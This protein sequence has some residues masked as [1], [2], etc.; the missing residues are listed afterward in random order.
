MLLPAERPTRA[1]C[2]AVAA[3]VIAALMSSCTNAEQQPT[4]T[5]VSGAMTLRAQ[6]GQRSHGPASTGDTPCTEST[7]TG[8]HP[9]VV[10]EPSAGDDFSVY[11]DN[12]CFAYD[13]P[14]DKPEWSDRKKTTVGGVELWIMPEHRMLQTDPASDPPDND[15]GMVVAMVRNTGTTATPSNAVWSGTLDPQQD[16]LVWLSKDKKAVLFTY[17]PSDKVVLLASNG[18]W[19]PMPYTKNNRKPK[20]AKALWVHP[21]VTGRQISTGEQDTTRAPGT[22]WIACL[23]GCCTPGGLFPELTTDISSPRPRPGTLPPSLLH[24]TDE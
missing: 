24:V 2:C 5:A 6:K 10:R 4:D 13:K 17:D 19:T 12:L 22:G 18:D 15:K 1:M 20:H 3:V 21:G 11:R 9:F 8:V 7:G 23:N 16:A 14:G